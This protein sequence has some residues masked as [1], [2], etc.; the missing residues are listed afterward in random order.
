MW[1]TIDN[2]G[3]SKGVC[4]MNFVCRPG[5]DIYVSTHAVDTH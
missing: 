4:S 2:M 5:K 1:E 3:L